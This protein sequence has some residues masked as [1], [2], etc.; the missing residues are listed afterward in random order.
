MNAVMNLRVSQNAGNFFSSFSG[1]TL[2]HAVGT[3]VE[4]WTH[5]VNNPLS[6]RQ[7]F[8]TTLTRPLCVCVFFFR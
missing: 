4:F 8:F 3:N 1:R 5:L 7:P 6:V 2:L